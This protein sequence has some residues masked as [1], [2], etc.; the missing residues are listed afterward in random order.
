MPFAVP[1]W[2]D[3]LL[4]CPECNA[5]ALSRT[6]INF[7]CGCCSAEYPVVNAVPLLIKPSMMVDAARL[8]GTQYDHLNPEDVQAAFGTAL[9]YRLKDK[10]LRDE[11]SGILDRYAV[12]FDT[13]AGAQE[14][15]SGLP[16][17]PLVDY[18]NPEFEAGRAA[19]RSFRFRN[20]SA[21]PFGTEGEKPF[22]VSYVITDADGNRTDGVRSRFP[23]PLL[24]GRDMTVPVRIA[25]PTAAGEYEIKVM[26]VQE[27]VRWYDDAPVYEGRMSVRTEHGRAASLV[28][29]AHEGH[30]DFEQDLANCGAILREAVA[31]ARA[32]TGEAEVT[33]LEVACGS[34]PQALRYFQPG[35]RVVACDL[36]FPQVQ[37]GALAQARK[38]VDPGAYAFASTDVF[39][40][41]F[42]PKSFQIIVIC[43]ALHH[44]TD[45]VEAFRQL[46]MLLADG[47]RIVI[48]R[49]PGKVFPE[50]PTYIAELANGFNE[51]QF[52]LA[53]YETMF[54][55]SGLRIDYHQLDY[56]CSYK[57]ILASA[58]G[59]E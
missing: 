59:L 23:V 53:E 4:R 51:Q 5:S 19:F 33:I 18:F 58:I 47:G 46:K 39:N 20:G 16:V 41:P 6:D 3:S 30:F 2:L 52:E 1:S 54:Q 26:V 37:L 15:S 21:V 31:A 17:Q 32:Q 43:A 56:E 22:H 24:P 11:F 29:P 27:Y 38:G 7:S 14:A 40:A 9:R 28:V 36:A 49:E 13:D 48:L 12:L 10:T 8:I 35:T 55:R 25:A 42:K 34:D 57:A 50:D 44:F 45:I